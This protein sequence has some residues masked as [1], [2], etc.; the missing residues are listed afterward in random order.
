MQQCIA[1]C[2][3][4]LPRFYELGHDRFAGY[5]VLSAS[6]AR[7]FNNQTDVAARPSV[8]GARPL[9]ADGER[10]A[11][12]S[13]S[14]EAYTSVDMFSMFGFMQGVVVSCRA[15]ILHYPFLSQ[16]T[17]QM[18]PL[19]AA[20]GRR[21]LHFFAVHLAERADDLVRLEVCNVTGSAGRNRGRGNRC[22]HLL[23]W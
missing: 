23:E 20:L 1:V 7:R 2:S 22:V 18:F 16:P 15:P 3:S 5:T 4:A 10:G 14:V 11:G 17:L 13:V 8:E 6:C 9:V 12:A 21:W 19:L